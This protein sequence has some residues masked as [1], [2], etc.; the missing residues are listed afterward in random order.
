M[1]WFNPF[2]RWGGAAERKSA[3]AEDDSGLAIRDPVSVL[4][5][6]PVHWHP[7]YGVHVGWSALML[8]LAIG[9]LGAVAF[10]SQL[11]LLY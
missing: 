10:V 9:G 7:Q 3:L 4:R 1:A 11:N 5:Q 8:I 6:T 2:T